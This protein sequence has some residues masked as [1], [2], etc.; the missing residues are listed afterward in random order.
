MVGEGQQV[1]VE[2]TRKFQGWNVLIAEINHPSAKRVPSNSLT[3]RY[4]RE[5][6]ED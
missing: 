3:I 2:G 5:G 1:W 4:R 6:V